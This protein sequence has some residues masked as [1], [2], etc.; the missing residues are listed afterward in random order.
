MQIGLIGLGRMG[1][2]IARRLIQNGHEVVVYDHDPKA[3]AAASRDGA[4]G[5]AGLDKLVQQLRPPRP[6]WIM[7]PAGKVTENIIGELAKL[8]QAGDIVL[9]GGNTFWKD[10]IRRAKMLK[11]RNIHHVDVGT[12]GG[13]WG[14][15]RGYCMM[16]GGAKEIVDSLDPIFKALAPGLGNVPRTTGRDGRDPRAELG[17]LHAGPNGAGHFV[18]MVH[19]GIEYGLMQAFAEGF[20]I[21]KN[22]DSEQL[23]QDARFDLDLTDIAEVWRRGSVISSWLL[24]LTASA[25]A[26]DAELDGF[27]R[28][29]RGFR[30]RPLDHYGGDR[31]SGAGGCALG[32][33]IHSLPL[34]PRTILLRKKFSR[35]CARV[36]ARM[37]SRNQSARPKHHDGENRDRASGRSVLPRDFRRVGRPHA[38]AAGAGALQSRRR[39]TAAGSVCVDRRARAA[40]RQTRRS[41]TISPKACRNSPRVR[42]TRAWSSVCWPASPMCRASPTT[43][44]PTKKSARSSPASS[45]SAAPRATGC[46]ISRRRRRCSPPIGC[47]LGQSGLAREDNGA[48]RRVVIEKPF[49]TDLASARALNQELLGIL[50]E[51][52]IFRIDH[53]LGKET[54]Q[55]ILVLRFANGLFEPIWNRDH[56][57]HVQITVAES[58]TVGRRGSYYDATGALRDMVPNHL[59]QLLSLVAMEPPARFAADAVRAEK[60]QLL[61][62]IDVPGRDEALRNAVR[63]Q[64]GDGYIENK[65]V[66]P[67]RKT[68]D[69]DPDS[70]TETYVALKLMIDNWRW[71]GVPFYLRTGKALRAKQTEVAI[72]FK[73]APVAMFRDT[74]VDRL[75]ENFL[76]IG[77]QPNECIGLEFNAKIPGPSIAIGGVG[78]TFKYEDYFDTPPSTGYETLIYDCMIGDAIL[79]PRADGIEAGWR[80]VQPF[81]DAWREAPAQDLATYR[82]GSEGPAEADRASR[83]AT[84]AAGGRS[85]EILARWSI[86]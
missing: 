73:Q 69:V 17:Y 36:L 32:C 26:V 3:I 67:Y 23:P 11:E 53:Y 52:Q 80:V 66:E 30:R 42:S 83:R 16:I 75:A 74:P 14:L 68:K 1:G 51:D 2:N 34:A 71:A 82:A 79:Y 86:E 63:G 45:V 64:Y 29:S 43:R 57:D 20:D 46:S 48:W 84:A 35:R 78:M 39:R 21:L 60:A 5:A 72:K 12:S 40:H 10:D 76:V 65:A 15:E 22:A 55:N 37:S 7:L 18:K 77:I 58:L 56:I 13:I 27:R 8:L 85:R 62:A 33:A 70:T 24:D 81:L 6:V 9:D 54:V 44:R 19:N 41:A 50:N 31:G 59:F 47:H 4:T 38:S 49:G 61:D 25:L 28:R